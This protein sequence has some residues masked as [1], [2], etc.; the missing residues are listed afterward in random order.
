MPSCRTLSPAS[1]VSNLQGV[2]VLHLCWAVFMFCLTNLKIVSLFYDFNANSC[3]RVPSILRS[4][5]GKRKTE[6]Y[7]DF[8]CL[9]KLFIRYV[10]K[11]VLWW[12][13][14][15]AVRPR[16]RWKK[17][18]L[19]YVQVVHS[20]RNPRWTTRDGHKLR[21]AWQRQ[22]WQGHDNYD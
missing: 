10:M 8:R 22:P 5:W 20:A 17:L 16:I 14:L 19:M 6:S 18:V 1:K 9:K 2:V 13:G 12:W 3:P 11:C 4:I 7:P 21:S 15:I